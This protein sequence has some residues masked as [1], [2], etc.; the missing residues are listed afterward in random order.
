MSAYLHVPS[1]FPLIQSTGKISPVWLQFF[2]NLANLLNQGV[3]PSAAG[4]SGVQIP[5][6]T[7]LTIVGLTSL[8]VTNGLITGHNP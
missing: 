5:Q 8:T 7:T 2:T 1:Q 3:P 6:S 4:P